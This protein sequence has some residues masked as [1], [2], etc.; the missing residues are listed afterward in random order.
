MKM[1]TTLLL[2][3]QCNYIFISMDIRGVFPKRK[4]FWRRS[5]EKRDCH[6]WC[7]EK[8]R[9]TTDNFWIKVIFSDESKIMIGHD[10]R[11]HVWRKK[12][13][14][15]RPDLVT[16]RQSKPCYEVM[17]WGC[18]T[19]EGVGTVTAVNGN[20][21]AE[22]YQ[23]TLDENLWPV[24]ARH[25][26]AGNFLFQQDNAPVHRARSTQQFLHRNNINT[27][28]WPAQSPDL[29]IIENLWLLIKTKLQTRVGRIGSKDDLFREII[30]IW[31]AITTDYVR[32][33]YRSIPRRLLS[34][35]RLKGHLTKY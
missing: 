22:K 19:W 23:E 14:G 16:L 20:I 21:N 28:S 7:R 11:V 35:I 5:I 18:V 1:L 2:N 9:L 33:L 30:D 31:T 15:W 32:S 27:L 34:V 24:I 4:L 6:A 25:F 12:D 3:A 10:S 8:R 26:P 13:E 29:N 17:V